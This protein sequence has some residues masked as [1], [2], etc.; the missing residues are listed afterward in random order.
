MLCYLKRKSCRRYEFFGSRQFG[1]R[2]QRAPASVPEPVLEN[3]QGHGERGAR[4]GKFTAFGPEQAL[5]APVIGDDEV[6]GGQGV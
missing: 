2:S 1:A 5:N 4:P 3:L 6:R